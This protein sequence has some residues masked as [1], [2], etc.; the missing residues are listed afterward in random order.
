MREDPEELPPV[1]PQPDQP[2]DL[3]LGL[4]GLAQELDLGQ[5][6]R[7][8]LLEEHLPKAGEGDHRRRG[9]GEGLGGSG[10]AERQAREVRSPRAGWWYDAST[11]VYMNFCGHG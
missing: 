10:L 2:G 7:P 9:K 1:V 5:L 8:G 4:W 6:D 11:L 3:P